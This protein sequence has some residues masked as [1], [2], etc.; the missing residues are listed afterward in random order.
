MEEIKDAKKITKQPD[1]ISA[2]IIR[3]GGHF[4]LQSEY[5]DHKTKISDQNVDI[6]FDSFTTYLSLYDATRTNMS[7]FLVLK[8]FYETLSK[9]QN[10]QQLAELKNS[11]DEL[12]TM[13]GVINQ[14]YPVLASSISMIGVKNANM[15]QSTYEKM[16]QAEAAKA[17]NKSQAKQQ[18]SGANEG[19]ATQD[20]GSRDI[21][22]VADKTARTLDNANGVESALVENYR[23][24]I[25]DNASDD[26]SFRL[27]RIKS[28]LIHYDNKKNQTYI[29]ELRRELYNTFE[30]IKRKEDLDAFEEVMES[31]ARQG[32]AGREFYKEYDNVKEYY[33]HIINARANNFEEFQQF[34]KRVMA[35]YEEF[36]IDARRG[37]YDTDDIEVLISRMKQLGDRLDE[38]R[39]YMD[40]NQYFRYQEQIEENLR[41]LRR[42]MEAAEEYQRAA[43]RLF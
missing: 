36:E 37:K 7:Q 33:S 39:D 26:L 24:F 40:K 20:V 29:D 34:Y 30:E 23:L 16:Y 18:A 38:N 9:V 27:L 25:P 14:L 42:G 22:N 3:Q 21:N 12:K 43:R 13:G 31:F 4:V 32:E 1:G 35:E 2:Y 19:D 8:Q 10:E 6:S 5:M 11:L 41:K 15:L 17:K 28:I